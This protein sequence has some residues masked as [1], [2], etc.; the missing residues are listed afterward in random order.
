MLSGVVW[1]SRRR[2]LKNEETYGR[3]VAMRISA[4]P[5][6]NLGL[7]DCGFLSHRL[8]LK[9]HTPFFRSNSEEAMTRLPYS[10]KYQLF[11]CIASF[12]DRRTSAIA[13]SLNLKNELSPSGDALGKVTAQHPVASLIPYTARSSQTPFVGSGVQFM[14]RYHEQSILG[15]Q[16]TPAVVGGDRMTLYT[17]PSSPAFFKTPLFRALSINRRACVWLVPIAC[18]IWR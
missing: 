16:T 17:N 15:I 7:I 10:T 14:G 13:R 4:T 11:L 1:N 5:T 12:E 8:C 6:I 9:T 2:T 18:P 3:T